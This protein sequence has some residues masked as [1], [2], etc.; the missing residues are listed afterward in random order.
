MSD[1]LAR[2]HVDERVPLQLSPAPMLLL[3]ACR[4]G[5]S[6]FGF[7]SGRTSGDAGANSRMLNGLP[8]GKG[9][10]HSPRRGFHSSCT[11]RYRFSK[12]KASEFQVVFVSAVARA[13]GSLGQ[14][15]YQT[16][17]KTSSIEWLTEQSIGSFNT[18][19]NT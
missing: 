8:R 10:Y 5:T 14:W 19:K 3:A 9:Q 11:R 7:N 6:R 12:V 16:A 1:L 4:T 2:I 15:H 17:R 13:A 18:T